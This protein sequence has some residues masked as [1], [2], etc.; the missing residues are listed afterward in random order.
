MATEDQKQYWSDVD[1]LD[2]LTQNSNRIF[3][4]SIIVMAMAL[5]SSIE[6][7]RKLKPPKKL[8]D[9]AY[10]DDEFTEVLNDNVRHVK[11]FHGI[12]VCTK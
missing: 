6:G 7:L 9:F 3:Y 10:T 12:S 1:I 4:D 2:I 5:N 8:E 11:E